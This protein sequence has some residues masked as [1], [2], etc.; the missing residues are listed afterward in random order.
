[1]EFVTDAA[2]AGWPASARE[3]FVP[4]PQ[5]YDVGMVGAAYADLAPVRERALRDRVI[6]VRP[7][8][9]RMSFEHRYEA[10]RERVWRVLMDPECRRR[11]LGVPRV[12]LV[13]GA[14]GT[15][16]GAEY[17][18]RHGKDLQERSVFRVTGYVMP[19]FVTMYIDFP[20]IG[21]VYC[22]DRLRQIAG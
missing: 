3:G 11:F 22:T 16:L 2:V 7:E 12:D 14:K 18:C 13:P 6:E 10:T 5:T 17:H 8:D 9:S 4:A 20:F 19:E 21:H 1:M 15:L